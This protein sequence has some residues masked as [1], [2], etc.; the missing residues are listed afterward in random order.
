[1]DA[2]YM[3]SMQAKQSCT[4]DSIKVHLHSRQ[5]CHEIREDRLNTN[6]I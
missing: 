5:K 4:T 6:H 3:C 2:R 1:M